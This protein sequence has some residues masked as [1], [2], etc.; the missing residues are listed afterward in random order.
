MK[1]FW[2]I[3]D[4]V[5]VWHFVILGA[6]AA[7]V[8]G[9]A[10]M[11]FGLYNVSARVGHWPGVSWVLHTTF[12]NSVSLRADAEVP[13]DLLSEDRIALGARH[14]ETACTACHG[15]PGE[16]QSATTL[17]MV[18][19]PPHVTEFAGEWPAEEFHWIVHEGIKMSGMPA[20]PAERE[21]DVWPV[22]A[23]LEVGD[24]SGADYAALTERP[25]GQYCAMCHGLDGVSGN[26]WIP[27]LDILSAEYMAAAL[28][29][30]RLGLRDSGIMHQAASLLPPASDDAVLEAYLG[31]V[32]PANGE[33]PDADLAGTGR[34]LAFAEAGSGDVPA[35]RA[36]HG[37]WEAPLDE[38]F[39]SLAGQYAPYLEQQLT[40]W[41]DG[42]R[43]GSR[44]AELMHAAAAELTDDDI[45]ALA[46]W[47]ASLPPARLNDVREAE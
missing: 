38:S 4:W 32:G 34:A 30:Y 17:A 1:R 10:V 6:V 43:G 12:G 7:I 20:W 16:A 41:R 31:E 24:M 27:R 19:Q 42:A 44:V 33:A 46:A 22:V 28:D 21:D 39:P 14:Y 9:A 13:E 47:Y 5:S 11:F 15:R 23:F 8:V 2:K 45:A 29:A 36:C 26:A 25:D 37:P 40:L 35:C 3:D 18:P